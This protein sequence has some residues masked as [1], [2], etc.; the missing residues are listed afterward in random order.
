[1]N[2]VV[3]SDTHLYEPTPAF[4]ELCQRF[5]AKADL[6]I[7]LGDVVSVSVLNYLMQYPLQAVAGNTDTLGVRNTLPDKKIIRLG[8][9]RVGLIHGWGSAEDLPEKLRREFSGVDAIFFGHSHRGFCRWENGLFWFNP[10]SVSMGRG[11]LPASIGLVRV[12]ARVH[13][14][15]IPI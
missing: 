14:E 13:G 3:M 1:M 5:C 11:G 10:G 4:A 2:V 6:V 9:L 12:D 15:I 7:H 8:R